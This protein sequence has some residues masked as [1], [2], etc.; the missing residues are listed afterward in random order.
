MT[1]FIVVG[2]VLAVLFLIAI[3]R[4]SVHIA[5]DEDLRVS[6]LVGGIIVY[7]NE[8]TKN[9]KNITDP[10]I[11]DTDKKDTDKKE[12]IFKKIYKEKGLKYTVDLVSETLKSVLNKLLWLLKRLK[13]RNFKLSLSVVGGDAA[14]TAIKYGAVCA[15]VYPTLAFVDSNLDFKPKSID[16]YA[17]F[18]GKN[19]KFSLSTDIK[20]TI[21]VLLVL[22]ISCLKEYLKIKKR[23]ENDLISAQNINNNSQ[24]DVL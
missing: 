8:K 5:Y 9:D 7:S 22:A 21:F 19:I 13:I 4:I 17:D 11:S 6:V 1:A 15:A 12:N 10:K 3:T 16:I 23:V 14:D 24:K 20:A 18:E 2:V